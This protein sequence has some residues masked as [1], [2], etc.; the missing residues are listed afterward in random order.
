MSPFEA[1]IGYIPRLPL[2]LLAPVPRSSTLQ[3]G[4][5]Y[6]DR[7]SKTV[8]VLRERMEETQLAMTVEANEH[9]QPHLYRVGDDVFLDT[10][11]LP[12]GYANIS[13]TSHDVVNSRKFQHPF[14]G[15]LKLMK[16]V[17]ENTFLLDIPA[18][19]RIHPVFNVACLKLSKVD[20][21]R[22]PPPPPPLRSTATRAPEYDVEAILQHQGTTVRDLRYLVQWIRYLDPSW[23]P[24]E[25]LRGTCNDQL[26]DYHAANGLRM[27]RWMEEK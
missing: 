5:E 10:H 14:A 7:L 15:P 20:R 8:R 24:L 9:Q 23:E 26:R 18:H 13:Q 3:P 17:G 1:D 2:D 19:Q 22:E 16:K 25:N 21:T 27:Y 12:V 4:E 11:L 6:A